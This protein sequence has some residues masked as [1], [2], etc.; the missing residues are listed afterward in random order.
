MEQ[1]PGTF[2]KNNAAAFYFSPATSSLTPLSLLPLAAFFFFC[3]KLISRVTAVFSPFAEKFAAWTVHP[4]AVQKCAGLPFFFFFLVGF[5]ASKWRVCGGLSGFPLFS[6]HE[7]ERGRKPAIA[8]PDTRLK[9]AGW[10]G[11]GSRPH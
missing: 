1:D 2:G 10:L 11:R 5:P 6:V 4:D 3:Y 7:R 8:R 9:I